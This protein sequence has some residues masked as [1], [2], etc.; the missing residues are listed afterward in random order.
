MISLLLWCDVLSDKFNQRYPVA[1]VSGNHDDEWVELVILV[2]MDVDYFVM[3]EAETGTS[4]HTYIAIDD[5]S[6]IY[7]S[8]IFVSCSGIQKYLKTVIL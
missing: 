4:E 2:N 3:F 6:F 5:V 8:V 1:S 7:V